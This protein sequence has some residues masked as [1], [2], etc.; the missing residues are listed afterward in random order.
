MCRP[1]PALE[2]HAVEPDAASQIVEF[3]TDPNGPYTILGF[4]PPDE[5]GYAHPDLMPETPFYYRIRAVHGPAT[6]WLT[7]TLPDGPLPDD[8][9]A[10]EWG[11]P[12]DLS[13][14]VKH[15]NGIA[16][17]WTDNASDEEGYLLEVRPAGSPGFRVATV[18]DPNVNSVGLITLPDEKN[19]TYR[20]Q[21]FYYGQSSNGAHQRTGQATH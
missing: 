14:T 9:P 17:T 13:A 15:A 2:W 10:D 21:A 5:T 3:A 20:V 4:L 8:L 7:V 6:T 12:T 19:A 11:A 1:S 16:F 18:L